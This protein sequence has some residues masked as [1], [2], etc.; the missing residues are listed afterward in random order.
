MDSKTLAHNSIYTGT[1]ESGATRAPN[2]LLSYGSINQPSSSTSFAFVLSTNVDSTTQQ[3][4]KRMEPTSESPEEIRRR[5]SFGGQHDSLP[6][7]VAR[8]TSDAE[9]AEEA[10]K[11]LQRQVQE[12]AEAIKQQNIMMAYLVETVGKLVDHRSPEGIPPSAERT[13]INSGK[14]AEDLNAD[15]NSGADSGVNSGV[16]SGADSE[17]NS[18]ADKPK[19]WIPV[20]RAARQLLSVYALARIDPDLHNTTKTRMTTNAVLLTAWFRKLKPGDVDV[21]LQDVQQRGPTAA[22]AIKTY[23]TELSTT[24]E[25]KDA[26]LAAMLLDAL[27]SDSTHARSAHLDNLV[28]VAVE[29]EN[30]EDLKATVKTISASGSYR[31]CNKANG[32]IEQA[33]GYTH[34]DPSVNEAADEWW[35]VLLTAIEGYYGSEVATG[36]TERTA[37]VNWTARSLPGFIRGKFEKKQEELAEDYIAREEMLLDLRRQ[38]ER[39]NEVTTSK[40]RKMNILAGAG[41]KLAKST[42][43]AIT[44]ANKTISTITFEQLADY[45]QA[46]DQATAEK[47]EINDI[48]WAQRVSG[49]KPKHTGEKKKKKNETDDG[50]DPCWHYQHVGPC[51]FG[52][53]CKNEHIG[54]A[55][56]LRHLHCDDDGVCLHYKKGDCNR[57]AECK[58]D[59]PEGAPA[60]QGVV[61]ARPAQTDA[62]K[63]FRAREAQ[64]LEDTSESDSSSD[65]GWRIQY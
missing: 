2:S 7:T 34:F 23:R 59:H 31:G 30:I 46:A 38:A 40:E 1:T 3:E 37:E 41:E 11:Q 58:F 61:Q 62:Q 29:C 14:Q 19:Q 25:C 28:R 6:E 60:E 9:M 48:L 22:A 10:V 26:T 13:N 53:D 54:E 52:D 8:A 18:E 43:R 39:T 36:A 35:Q 57:G 24:L 47:Q 12:Q 51:R 32:D 45:L 49:Q 21:L 5:L 4:S 50:K 42:L 44:A 15:S 20:T 65:D 63:R 33:R 27:T 64:N 55:G 56:S 16:N 17:V